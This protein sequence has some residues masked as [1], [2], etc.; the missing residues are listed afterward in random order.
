MRTYQQTVY[1]HQ[2][3]ADCLKWLEY[4]WQLAENYIECYNR[5][6]DCNESNYQEAAESIEQA[7]S[8]LLDWIKKYDRCGYDELKN[9]MLRWETHP[10]LELPVTL[11]SQIDESWV[12]TGNNEKDEEQLYQALRP[13]PQLIYRQYQAGKYEESAGN[14]LYMLQRLAD[15]YSRRRDLFTMMNTG[16]YSNMDI[17]R[18]VIFHPLCCVKSTRKVSRDLKY[19]I[20]DS[21]E[22]LSTDGFFDLDDSQCLEMMSSKCMGTFKSMYQVVYGRKYK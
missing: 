3:F 4:D 18:E 1:F 16:T 6:A 17:L 10:F 20:N 9:Y 7:F 2:H 21:L 14:A 11:K 15:L 12:E 19:F 8:S 5:L 13:Y 22:E